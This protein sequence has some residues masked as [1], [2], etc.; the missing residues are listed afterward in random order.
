MG[1]D[2]EEM[3]LLKK[4]IFGTRDVASNWEARA[5]QKLGYQLELSSKI[6]FRQERHQVSGMTHG[7]D[8]VLTGQTERLTEFG[9]TMTGVYPI[10][11]KLISYGSADSIKVL[12]RRLPW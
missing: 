11:A 12:N 1:A 3:G 2:A 9:S 4:S 5:R 10:K 6:L 7:E 8:F